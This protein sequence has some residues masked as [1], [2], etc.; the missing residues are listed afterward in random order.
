MISNKYII[1]KLLG[2]GKF[3]KVYSGKYIKTGETVAIKIENVDSNIKLLKNET[4]I[5]NYLYHNG[6]RKTPF[7][8]WYGIHEN[9]PSLVMSCYE[10][11]LSDYI[12][13]NNKAIDEKIVISKIIGILK[14][15]HDA[16]IIHRDI[17]PQNFMFKTEDLYLVD[18]GLAT[19]YVDEE[20]KHTHESYDNNN[21]LGTPKYISI[22]LHEG[23]SPSRRDDIISCG[24]VY[25]F[26]L[27]NGH[28][29]WENLPDVAENIEYNEGHILHYKN[30]ERARQKSW[31]HLEAICQDIGSDSLSAFFSKIQTIGFHDRPNYEELMS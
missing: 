21:I 25:L 9:C 6:C 3:G 5:L 23:H 19:T 30:Q 13:N 26:L 27:L 29:P 16:Y 8:Y 22:Y 4:A 11:S 28:L 17:K 12:V 15:I 31:N 7:V 2:K 24:Y 18:F 10:I 14:S 20:K 1:T